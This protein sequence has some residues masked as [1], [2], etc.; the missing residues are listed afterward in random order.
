MTREALNQGI[1]AGVVP[2]L[3]GGWIAFS[4]DSEP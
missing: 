3:F 4:T 2:G 1:H